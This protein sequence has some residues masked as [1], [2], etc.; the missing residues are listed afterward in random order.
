MTGKYQARWVDVFSFVTALLLISIPLGAPADDPNPRALF[1]QGFYLLQNAQPSKAVEKFEE[2]L[3][4]DPNNAQAHYYL[5]EAY[6]AMSRPNMA[7][8]HYERSLFIDAHSDVA[9]DA[10]KRLA[11][12]RL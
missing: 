11:D 7:K 4:I 9:D 12:L 1:A 3:K 5:G 2:G 10:R 6:R 8:E